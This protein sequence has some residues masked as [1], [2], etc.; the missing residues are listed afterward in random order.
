MY[1]DFLLNPYFALTKR[2]QLDDLMPFQRLPLT[3][4]GLRR[5]CTFNWKG[6]CGG[7]V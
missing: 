2:L 6:I 3:I 5:H 4:R 7:T 1:L